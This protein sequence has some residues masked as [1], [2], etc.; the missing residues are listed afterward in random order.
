M[1]N[2]NTNSIAMQY[3]ADVISG[4]VITGKL[5]KLAVKRHLDDL[6]NGHKRGLYFDEKAAQHAID[7]FQYLKHVKDSL[8]GSVI[9]LEPFQQFR[10]W[11][12]F[13]WM[14]NSVQFSC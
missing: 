8:A 9:K 2:K 10:L 5:V 11:C 13:G 6:E 4:K 14:K 1:D 12:L 3:A 7:F